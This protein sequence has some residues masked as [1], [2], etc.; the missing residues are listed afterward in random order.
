LIILDIIYLIYLL[1]LIYKRM[2]LI[3]FFIYY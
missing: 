3:L 1:L 2:T